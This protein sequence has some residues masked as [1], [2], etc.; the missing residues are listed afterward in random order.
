MRGTVIVD[1]DGAYQKWLQKQRTFA[2]LAAA[3]KK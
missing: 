1:D 2:E 3:V